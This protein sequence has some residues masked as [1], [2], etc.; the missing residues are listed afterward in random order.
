LSTQHKLASLLEALITE[1]GLKETSIPGVM[2]VRADAPV[3]RTPLMYRPCIIVV[4]QG[5]KRVWLGDEVF[6]YD[7]NNYLVLSAPMPMECETMTV[8]DEPLLGLTISIDPITV[9]ELLL[10]IDDHS[11]VKGQPRLVGSTNV[12]DDVIDAATR[13]VTALGSTLRSSVLGE[14][15]VREMVF[16]VLQ[17]PRGDALRLLA[18]NS[19]RYGQIARVLRRIHDDYALDLDVASLAREANMGV[20]TF[21]QIF[22]DMTATSPLQYIKQTRLH[23]ARALLVAE[24]AS[25]QEAA[26]RVGYASPSQFGREYRRM[27]GVTPAAE[28][29]PLTA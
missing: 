8:G 26:Y 3:P 7:A 5:H 15:I 24:G 1:T 6:D 4:A 2:L 23:H 10:E 9:G 28:R 27:F 20:S 25:A 16:H 12:T 29:A 17:G 11:P 18:T 14:Q 22:R 21:H 19:T 13:L